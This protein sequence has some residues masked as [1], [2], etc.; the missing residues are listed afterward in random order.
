MAKQ[1]PLVH[2]KRIGPSLNHLKQFILDS[3]SVLGSMY[4]YDSRDSQNQRQ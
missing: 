4:V 1:P 3:N 2:L